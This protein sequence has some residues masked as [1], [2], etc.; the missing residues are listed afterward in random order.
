MNR[1]FTKQPSTWRVSQ[2]GGP[3]GRCLRDLAAL[4]DA[5]SY[6]TSVA[7]DSAPHIELGFRLQSL[8]SNLNFKLINFQILKA[9]CM[10]QQST[11]ITITSYKQLSSRCSQVSS[12]LAMGHVHRKDHALVQVAG[13]CAFGRNGGKEFSGE[14]MPTIN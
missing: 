3:Y 14:I 9:F 6:T 10:S 11:T 2:D 1:A 5:G 7:V 4:L 12:A 13:Q 8:L